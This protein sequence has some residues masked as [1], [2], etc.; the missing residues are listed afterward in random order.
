MTLAPELVV[1]ARARKSVL[2]TDI[3]GASTFVATYSSDSKPTKRI[4]F[5]HGIRGT[6]E[7]LEAI[8]GA[9]PST[10]CIVPDL[11]AFGRS[12]PLGGEHDLAALH[13]W[14]GELVNSYK[15]DAIV[16]HS[17][18]TLLVSGL[19]AAASIPLVL[20]N[21]VVELKKSRAHKLSSRLTNGFYGLCLALGESWGRG[22]CSSRL[23]VD[24]M[25]FALASKAGADVRRW[26][27]AQH[28]EH[29]S[30]FASLRSLSEHS[31][32]ATSLSLGTARMGKT[33][34]L[35]VAATSDAICDIEQIRQYAE[36]VPEASLETLE[37]YGHLIHYEAPELAAD[38]IARFVA[39]S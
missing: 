37:G 30:S 3:G 2:M 27:F 33:P 1:R 9:L 12:A 29:F 18:G 21:P 8:V 35:L 11:P 34:L 22:L 23:L 14:L 16:A 32:L 4:L 17:Y 38:A 15:P 5:I 24:A 36:Q 13:G 26:V 19:P 6:H 10:Q 28:R 20:I 7:G 39:A 31:K 25:S